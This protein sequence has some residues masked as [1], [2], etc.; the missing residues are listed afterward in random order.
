MLLFRKFYNRKILVVKKIAFI[1]FCL[2]QCIGGYSQKQLEEI[3]NLIAHGGGK[4]HGKSTT[5]AYEAFLEAITVKKYKY[6]EA[7]LILTSDNFIVASHDW[8]MFNT[9]TGHPEMGDSVLS[10]EEFKQRRIMNDYKPVTYVELL[11]LLKDYPDWIMVTDKL[12]D[13]DLLYSVFSE[14][15]DRIMVEAFSLDSYN[16]LKKVGFVPMLS[17]GKFERIFEYS[18]QLMIEGGGPVDFFTSFYKQNYELLRRVQCLMPMRVATYTIDLPEFIEE[19]LGNDIDL[20]YTDSAD[21]W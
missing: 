7:D 16:E 9:L 13:L 10:L 19:H 21:P 2:F 11:Q 6:V 14:Y 1:L 8:E 4:F 15:K 17:D 12:D 3:P 5:N 20:I 18:V